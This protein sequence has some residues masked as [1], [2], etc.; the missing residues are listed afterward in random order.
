MHLFWR[1]MSKPM[2]RNDWPLPLRSVCGDQLW[3]Q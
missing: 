1:L 2:R 3:L